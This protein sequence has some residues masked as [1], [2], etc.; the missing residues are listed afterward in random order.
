MYF[1]IYILLIVGLS[2]FTYF[3]YK[4][5]YV[6]SFKNE[7]RINETTLLFFSVFMG[8]IGGIFA[9]YKHKIKRQIWYFLVIN[10]AFLFIHIILALYLL[11][12]D[13]IMR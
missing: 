12:N 10:W 1:T 2:I 6:L 7:R 8:A 3:L 11:Y 4:K 13:I 9:I 5:D